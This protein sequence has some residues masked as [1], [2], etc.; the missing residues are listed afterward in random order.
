MIRPGMGA[1]SEPAERLGT[2]TKSGKAD[3]WTMRPSDRIPH[4]AFVPA[5]GSTRK[6]LPQTRSVALEI[7]HPRL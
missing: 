6:P 5:W 4:S 1:G 7:V 2:G 3:L